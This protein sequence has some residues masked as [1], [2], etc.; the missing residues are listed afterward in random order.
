M[1]GDEIWSNIVFARGLKGTAN[2]SL[3]V[4]ELDGPNGSPTG[5]PVIDNFSYTEDSF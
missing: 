1:E 3:T 2:I 4:Q 5:V